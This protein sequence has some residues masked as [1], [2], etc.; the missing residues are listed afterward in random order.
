MC[1][2]LEQPTSVLQFFVNPYKMSFGIVL[3]CFF[4]IW[5]IYSNKWFRMTQRCKWKSL[6]C[7]TRELWNYMLILASPKHLVP[8]LVRLFTWWHGGVTAQQ[9]TWRMFD[10]RL[11]VAKI[12]G[13]LG[14]LQRHRSWS[15]PMS[16]HQQRPNR[17]WS[18]FPSILAH[19]MEQILMEMMICLY[20]SLLNYWELMVE[21]LKWV[22]W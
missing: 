17:E 1:G 15:F 16:I 8:C 20:N 18:H 11:G 4:W 12:D 10:R 13:W 3:G 5:I 6:I 19:T 14:R 2:N 21:F 7:I 22:V 9:G